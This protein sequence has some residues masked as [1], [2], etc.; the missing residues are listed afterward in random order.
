MTHGPPSGEGRLTYQVIKAGPQPEISAF[1]TNWR[2]NQTSPGYSRRSSFN[3]EH[4]NVCNF[5]F[6]FKFIFFSTLLFWTKDFYFYKTAAQSSSRRPSSQTVFVPEP[7]V[8]GSAAAFQ[9]LFI[10]AEGQVLPQRENGILFLIQSQPELRCP[11]RTS[12]FATWNSLRGGSEVPPESSPK[13]PPVAIFRASPNSAAPTEPA[14]S[15]PGTLCEEEAKSLLNPA[16]KRS[17]VA[18]SGAA[19]GTL[20]LA[21]P[22]RSWTSPPRITSKRQ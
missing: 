20:H 8:N 6:T 19:P 15:P 16:P 10:P 17:P 12:A 3:R 5:I 14:E 18:I 9:L 4:T 7:R 1:P 2:L 22:H 11:N 21:S 13:R